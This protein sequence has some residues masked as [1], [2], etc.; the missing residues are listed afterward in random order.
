MDSEDLGKKNQFQKEVENE[1]ET[2]K[3]KKWILKNQKSI[4]SM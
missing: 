1:N 3:K 2:Q 4:L